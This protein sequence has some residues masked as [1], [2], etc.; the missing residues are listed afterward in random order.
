MIGLSVFVVLMMPWIAE[1]LYR[2]SCNGD[3]ASFEQVCIDE[4]RGGYLNLYD[5]RSLF[6]FIALFIGYP[7]LIGVL[8]M[9]ELHSKYAVW[10]M[11]VKYKG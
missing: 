1:C 6:S 2:V 9:I 5:I 3:I 11:K 10:R 4:Y 7:I 8:I